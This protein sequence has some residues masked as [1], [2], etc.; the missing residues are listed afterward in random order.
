[1][2]CPAP[3]PTFVRVRLIPDSSPPTAEPFF[4]RQVSVYSASIAW[5]AS[6]KRQ[7]LRRSRGRAI[8]F[9]AARNSTIVRCRNKT[10]VA[11]YP[12]FSTDAFAVAKHGTERAV[13]HGFRTRHARFLTTLKLV[14]KL[15]IQSITH[16]SKANYAD[17]RSSNTCVAG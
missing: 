6:F 7:I 10:I 16:K 14:V 1:M 12:S 13:A 11:L 9:P 17:F 8:G 5:N 2:P 3:R 4:R 15:Q